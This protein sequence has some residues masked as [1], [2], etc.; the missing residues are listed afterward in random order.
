MGG[1]DSNVQRILV[2]TIYAFHMPAFIFITGML[3]KSTR[4]TS[5]LAELVAILLVFQPM[6]LTFE[7]ASGHGFRQWYW[8]FWVLWFI[9]A[10]VWWQAMLPWIQR[11]P[12]AA[13]FVSLFLALAVGLMPFNGN[14]FAYHRTLVF[15]PFFVFGAALGPAIMS[16]IERR[17]R[18][19]GIPV[20][21]AFFSGVTVFCIIGPDPHWL[22]QNWTYDRLGVSPL[23]GVSLRLGI[24]LMSAAGTLALLFLIP[25]RARML[26]HWGSR[27]LPVFIFHVFGVFAFVW[28]VFPRTSGMEGALGAIVALLVSV[29]IVWVCSL[30]LFTAIAGGVR[31][32]GQRVLEPVPRPQSSKTLEHER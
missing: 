17:S 25:A 22:F 12:R 19:W 30:D 10:L 31:A 32:I 18:A 29:A 21:L 2:T 3:A 15:L 13:I 23:V 7:A 16:W 26:E 9:V 27:T 8:P 20:M 5:R 11:W 4:L 1:W 6:F 14:W 28:W 24:L